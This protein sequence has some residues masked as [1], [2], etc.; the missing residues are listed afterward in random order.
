MKAIFDSVSYQCSKNITKRY[1]TS[2]SLAVKMVSPSL[3]QDIYNIYGFVRLADEVVDTFHEYDK[4]RLFGDFEKALQD[5]LKHKISL[6]PV[7]NSFQHTV[8]RYQIEDEL[9]DAFMR[10]MKTDLTKTVYTNKEE[11]R[12]YI[13]GSADVVGLMCLRVFVKSDN[14]K[15][16]ALKDAAMALGS[17]FQKINFL[18]DLRADYE[19][20]ERSYFPGIN[21]NTLT[22][23]EKYTIITDIENDL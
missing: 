15:Y 13:Y 1:S 22:E 2:F 6:N 10:S 23:A 11:Y 12:A 18:R 9:I 20:L 14:E 3:R 17:T 7:L 19:L 21:F 16:N 4:K 5:A 8:H